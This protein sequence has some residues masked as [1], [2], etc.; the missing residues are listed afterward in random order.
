[1]ISGPFLPE[2]IFRTPNAIANELLKFGC[3]LTASSC[4]CSDEK[5]PQRDEFPHLDAS[6]EAQIKCCSFIK[7]KKLH[8][9]LFPFVPRILFLTMQL[10]FSAF[11]ASILKT[12]MADFSRMPWIRDRKTVVNYP[13]SKKHRKY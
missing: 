6:W 3:D 4:Q 13:T 9:G 7:K 2:P 11:S 8:L 1:M 10:I 5:M 12:N